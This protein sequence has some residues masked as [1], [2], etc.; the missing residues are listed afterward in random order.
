MTRH[1][2]ILADVHGNLTALEAVLADLQRFPTEGVLCLGDLGNFGPQP[3]E[4]L[5]H[6]RALQP[7]VIL[8]NS[9]ASQ[10]KPRTLADVERPDGDTLVIL[11]IESWCAAQLDDEDRDFLRSFEPSLRLD[12]GG[13]SLLAYHGSPKSFDDPIRATTPDETLEGYL[14]DRPADLYL[15]AHTHEQF[16]RRY[17]VSIVGNPGSVGLAFRADEGGGTVNVAIAEYALLEVQDGQANLHLRRV[18]YDLGELRA[19]VEAS[20]MPHG[21]RWL[22]DFREAAAKRTA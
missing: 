8:G 3:R 5:R 10:L 17:G 11:D 21:H 18:P 19:A 9:D 15:G 20:G 2:A 14:G 7:A 22:E 6:L 12:V 16:V 13:L 1:L 4:T